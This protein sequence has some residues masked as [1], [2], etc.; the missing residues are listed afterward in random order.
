MVYDARF[1]SHA[2]TPAQRKWV[3]AQMQAF[4]PRLKARNSPSAQQ[5]YARYV[6]G[7]LSWAA[8]RQ[9]LDAAFEA[10]RVG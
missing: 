4:L 6:A 7:E 1:G 5:L 3:L 10:G 8:M 9:A 2:Q